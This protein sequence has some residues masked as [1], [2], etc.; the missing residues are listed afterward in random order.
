MAEASTTGHEFAAPQPEKGRRRPSLVWLMPIIAVAV[1]GW[2]VWST[3]NDQ[4]PLITVT[5]PS[6]SGIRAET[7]ELRIRDL[8]VGIV[9]EVGFSDGMAAVEAHIRLDK[10]IAQ[11]VDADAR[12][13]LVEPQV[14][15]RGVTG[16]GT[17]LSGVYI[18]A[19]WDGEAGAPVDHFT[20]LETPPLTAFGEVGTRIVLRTRA[21]GQLA[22]G[23][24]VLT[25]G[26]EVGRIGQPVLSDTG[27]I[28]TMDAFVTAPYDQRL[29]TNTRFWDASGLSINVGAEGLAVNIDSLAALIEGGVSFGNPVTGGAAIVD[30]HVFEVFASEAAAR[31]DAFEGGVD[32]DV[33]ASVLLDADVSGLGIGTLV[34]FRGVKV[35]EVQDVAGV[36]PE[37]GSDEPVRLRIDMSLAPSRIGLPANLGSEEVEA[38]L[39]ERVADGWRVRVASEGLFGQTMILEILDLP[40]AAPAELAIGPEGRI[41][42]PGAPAAVS[43]GTANVE[44]LVDRVA[45]LPIEELMTAATD[46]LT[47]VSR[48]TG[49]A[50]GVLAADGIERIPA[51][52]DETLAE[53]R[54]LV[55]DVRA[56]GAIESLNVA[57]RTAE[58]TLE[59][60]DAA[61]RTLPGLA[62]RLDEAADGLQAVVSGYTPDSRIYNDV[63]EV[64]RE[65][66]SAAE[67]FRSL[68]RTIERNPNSLITGR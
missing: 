37:P 16:I 27:S 21:G 47:G 23:A 12:F 29:T 9:E 5:F 52:L 62:N 2:V 48:L 61:A 38:A 13:W 26:I 28:V 34:R 39:A 1:A 68:A 66:S 33:A 15:A 65:V 6:A 53:V 35:G 22:A 8:K 36:A 64:L 45:N 43:D 30:G 57:L 18:A 41:V 59:A 24:S 10:S 63:R 58:G 31:E 60:V 50:E 44:G 55:A 56:G 11:Y 67:A 19:S 4:G 46:A 7:T 49:T 32:P 14:T 3:Y 54:S 25:S 51:T 20:A 42:L 17:L 40:D